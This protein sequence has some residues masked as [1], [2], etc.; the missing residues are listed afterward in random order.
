MATVGWVGLGGIGLPMARALTRSPHDVVACGHRNVAAREAVA[1]AGARVVGSPK[2][3]AEGADIMVSVV[4]DEAQTESVLRGTDGVLAGLAAGSVLIVMS[5]L[6]ATYC[7][8]LAQDGAGRGIDVVD[9]PVS[10]GAPAAERGTLTI[11]VGGETPA[12]TRVQPVLEVLGDPVVHLGGIGSGQLAK[13]VNNAIKVAILAVTTEQLD[14]AVRAGLDVEALLR[15]LRTASANSHV[16][17]NWDY[18]YAF[19]KRHHPGGPLDILHKDISL[20]L[21]LAAEVGADAPI[22]AALK[23]VDVGRLI[24]T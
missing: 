15:V 24:S 5:T 3:A 11:M 7:R 9:A 1:A 23:G 20:A 6:S 22:A 12:V 19:K 16:V 17:Q 4:R 21:D 10:G 14:V 13:I 8:R 18:Y 2:E